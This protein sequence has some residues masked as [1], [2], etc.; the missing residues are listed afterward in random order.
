MTIAV[1]VWRYH[2][3]S[4][5]RAAVTTAS[6]P[7][8][9]ASSDGQ[10]TPTVSLGSPA[11]EPICDPSASTAVMP[12]TWARIVPKRTTREPPALVAMAP[13]TVAE[14]RLAK[15]SGRV[16]PG[17]PGVPAPAGQRDAGAGRHLQR[18]GVDGAERVEPAGRQHDHRPP[19]G[20]RR[21]RRARCCRP[22]ARPAAPAVGARPSTA[23]TS[24]VSA[25]RTTSEAS[26]R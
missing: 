21:R 25:G 9:P 12:A 19:R 14:S 24:S 26:P 18:A 22:A 13:P 2:G 8:L 11:S 6:V 23:A 10:C 3:T 7:S 15:S 16:E 1:A 20:A 5:S 17:V 4:R